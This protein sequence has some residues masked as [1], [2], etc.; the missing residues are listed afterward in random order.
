M[1]PPELG[2]C[3]RLVIV[4]VSSTQLT[5]EA[6]PPALFTDTAVAR[7]WREKTAID[8]AT[9]ATIPGFKDFQ[10]REAAREA[11]KLDQRRGETGNVTF[12]DSL[13]DAS[14]V[15]GSRGYS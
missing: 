13:A 11:K 9:L 10:Q 4:D 12:N 2:R 7:L 8:E 3:K 14:R 5:A 1:L 6:L 15:G